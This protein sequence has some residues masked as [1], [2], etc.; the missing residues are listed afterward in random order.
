M[1][2]NVFLNIFNWGAKEHI[3]R[4]SASKEPVLLSQITEKVSKGEK[5]KVLE[6]LNY[7]QNKCES[8]KAIEKCMT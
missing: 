3:V 4:K 7:Q 2:R 8:C 5:P 6:I 1:K